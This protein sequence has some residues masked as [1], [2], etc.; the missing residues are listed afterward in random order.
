MS[1]RGRMLGCPARFPP[2]ACSVYALLL[3]CRPFF[4]PFLSII[5]MLKP[6][7]SLSLTIRPPSALPP[8]LT[9]PSLPSPS[10][11]PTLPQN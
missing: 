8:S 2:A 7:L 4:F 9:S 3:A 10:S 5:C 11:L 6:S 1:C